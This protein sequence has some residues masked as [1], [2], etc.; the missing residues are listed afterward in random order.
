MKKSIKIIL[1]FVILTI[2]ASGCTIVKENVEETVS[3]SE[4]EIVYSRNIL[5]SI[6][7]GA[8]GYGTE[9]ECTDADI[10]VYRDKIVRV[11]MCMENSPEVA[12]FELSEEDYNKLLELTKPDRIVGFEIENDIEACDGSFYDITL[13]DENDEK[14][15]YRGG[16]MPIGEEFWEAYRS[17][18]DILKPYGIKESVDAYRETMDM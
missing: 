3:E 6:N 18:K 1:L 14:V 5:F 11:F 12:E 17:I 7:N 4:E 15:I 13:Y 16:Y 9:A 2:F 8:S 10:V